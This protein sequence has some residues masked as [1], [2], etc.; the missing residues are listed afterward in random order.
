MNPVSR[1]SI[2]EYLLPSDNEKEAGAHRITEVEL[3]RILD[4]RGNPTIEADVHTPAA[5]GRAAAPSGASTGEH[6][7]VVKPVH[8]AL[9]SGEKAVEALRGVDATD[10]RRV[11]AVLKEVDG[12]DN[13]S[14]IG[15]NTAV[16]ISMAAAK[17][18][19]SGLG[20]PLHHH[21]GGGLR[22]NLPTPLG[23]V[24]GGGEHARDAT[25]IQEF[26]VAP[27]GAESFE[28]AAFTNARIHREVGELLEEHGESAGL[29]DEGA[30]APSID[31]EEALEIVSEAA[32]AVETEIRLG[33]DVAASELWDP[34]REAYIYG[35]TE[36][37]R[38]EQIDY[39]EDLVRD[40][41]LIY[42]ED[43]LEENDFEGFASLTERVG[44]MEILI[45]GDDLFVTSE[46]RLG[47]GV[48]LGAG[49]SVLVKP[50]QVGTVTEAWR[51]VEL[52]HEEGYEAVLS[53]R[54]GETE[55]ATIAHLAVG[56]GAG[57]VKTGAVGGERTAKL[58]ELIRIERDTRV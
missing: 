1:K 16:A 10:Q 54:S 29:G 43:P 19:A 56:F 4:S 38:E 21:L 22:S 45:C 7:A 44:D 20:V 40:Y 42:V 37:S 48:E 9:E 11:D 47:R 55:D 6:E 57:Y 34:E 5:S 33:L 2:L 30:W 53:H 39:I 25:D 15:G 41:D 12:T 36:R 24:L 13:Y 18:A 14:G 27:V 46:E 52:A 17:A 28:E 51:T 3:R 8:V 26:L 32:A 58:N 35:D 49:N 23:N 50:N 31:D